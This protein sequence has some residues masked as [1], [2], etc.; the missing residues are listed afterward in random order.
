MDCDYPDV[1]YF[2]AVH[3]LSRAATL[4]RF[5]NQRS[6]INLLMESKDQNAA[7]LSDE[8][9]LNDLAFL[10]DIAQ[11]LNMK[12]QWKR[13]L[14]NKLFEHICALEKKFGTVSVSVG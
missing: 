5:W 3:L 9:W 13:Q 8:N 4:M 1:G 10:T 2:S 7:F 12:L 11:Q 6:D 14:V